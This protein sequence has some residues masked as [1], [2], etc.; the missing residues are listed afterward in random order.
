MAGPEHRPGLVALKLLSRRE[1]SSV[2]LIEELARRGFSPEQAAAEVEA[3]TRFGALDDLRS[4]GA[5]ARRLLEQRGHGR[6]G[7]VSRLLSAGY[8]GELVERVLAV[9]IEESGWEEREVAA[10]LVARRGPAR[11]ARSVARLAR[12]LQARGFD[13]EVVRSLVP[14]LERC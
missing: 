3:V 8:P 11:D 13:P 7:L 5:R 10:A 14:G 12:F 9:A 6:G 2:H 1:I 4:A